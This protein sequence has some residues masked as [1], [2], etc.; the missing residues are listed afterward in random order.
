MPTERG[1]IEKADKEKAVVRVQKHSA[2]SHCES[3]G[4]CHTENEG[5]MVIEVENMIGAV[6][7][8]RVEITVPTGS[9]MKI[10]IMVYM[11]PVLAFLL[12]A[13]LG[14]SLGRKISLNPSLTAII[15]GIGLMVIFFYLLKRL[16]KTIGNKERYKPRMTRILRHVTQ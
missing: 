11:L 8:D 12:G 4:M 13:F 14:D 10:T 6:P 2:C 16:D 15:G 7:G 9:F 1:I 5:E 3:R